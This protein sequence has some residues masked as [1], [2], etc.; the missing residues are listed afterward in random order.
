M[1]QY[2]SNL[3][4]EILRIIVSFVD[5]DDTLCNMARVCHTLYDITI[6]FLYDHIALY[7]REGCPG[8]YEFKTLRPLT[9]LLLK[10]PDLARLVHHFTAR[11]SFSAG[12]MTEKQIKQGEPFN[13]L[14]VDDVFKDAIEAASHDEAEKKQWL[15]QIT[16]PDH[17]DAILALL[18]PALPNLE[19]LDLMLG[20]FGCTY[21]EKMMQ[22]AGMREKPFDKDR[23]FLALKDVMHAWDNDKYGMGVEYIGMFMRLPSIERI[24][25]HR[26]GS[27]DR[28]GAEPDATLA[29]LQTASSTVSHIELKNCKL[30]ERDL[31]NMLRAPKA[32][33]TFIYEVGWGYL[34]YCDM[35][36]GAAV[37]ALAPQVHYLENLWLDF[38]SW[39]RPEWN[40]QTDDTTPIRSF[41]QFEILKVLKVAIVFIFGELEASSSQRKDWK[42]SELRGLTG[43]FPRSLETLH[44]L[45]CEDNFELVL[46][47]LENMLK[48]KERDVPRLSKLVFEGLVLNAKEWWDRMMY[49][50]QLSKTKG[51]E[52]VTVTVPEGAS[53]HEGG[54]ERGWG[55]DR[56]IFWGECVDETNVYR[57]E[58]VV[59]WQ[60]DC[61]LNR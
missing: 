12:F 32:L 60:L 50:T 7:D 44:L 57:P 26:V 49:L 54:V 17:A 22:R 18:L 53:R 23:G 45:H 14:K 3:P 40:D 28:V 52:M 33:K 21:F 37:S 9:L 56:D 51:V 2:F 10:R 43:K 42:E 15:E 4:L 24:F 55:M 19:S 6:P 20:M 30:D 29:A 59:D 58:E 35:V 16:W 13:R 41:A 11:E 25:G 46:L 36:F 34:S 39:V 8:E 27:D 47:A 38:E 31:A 1:S 5:S 48:H 61:F